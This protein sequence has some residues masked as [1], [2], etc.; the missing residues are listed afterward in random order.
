MKRKKKSATVMVVVSGEALEHVDALLD[1]GLYGF[2]R[3]DVIERLAMAHLAAILKQDQQRVGKKPP[4]I[5][6]KQKKRKKRASP[7]RRRAPRAEVGS[8]E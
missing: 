2:E 6:F 8:T 3:S 5:G 7:P 4:P 1:T